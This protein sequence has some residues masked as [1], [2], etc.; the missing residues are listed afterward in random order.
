MENTQQPGEEVHHSLGESCAWQLKPSGSEESTLTYLQGPFP[1]YDLH[2]L[3]SF[4]PLSL[5]QNSIPMTFLSISL[6]IPF[7]CNPPTLSNPPLKIFTLY[8]LQWFSAS[9]SLPPSPCTALQLVGTSQ[10]G[11]HGTLLT[12]TGTAGLIQ[13]ET[14]PQRTSLNVTM[15]GSEGMYGGQGI[16]PKGSKGLARKESQQMTKKW[17]CSCLSTTWTPSHP[18]IITG[19]QSTRLPRET[20]MSGQLSSMSTPYSAP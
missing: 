14:R 2:L 16:P 18:P 4:R 5:A 7:F 20:S 1:V 12:G 17:S 8:N 15:L 3:L 11:S 6:P 9:H 13:E 19:P 10:L